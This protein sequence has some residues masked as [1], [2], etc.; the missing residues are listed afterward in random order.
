LRTPLNAVIGITEMLVED[1]EELG[2]D[3]LVEPLNRI[4][5]AGKHLLELINEV[6]DL[7]KIEAGKLELH[8]EDVDVASLLSDLVGAVQPLAT[9]NGNHLVVRGSKEA[10]TIRA[11]PMRLRQIILNLL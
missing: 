3:G 8:E 11:D 9:K 7:S 10:G 6:L 4:A 1:V 2:Q 5:R